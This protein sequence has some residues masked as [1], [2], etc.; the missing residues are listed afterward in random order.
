MPTALHF[1]QCIYSHAVRILSSEL[2]HS[3]Y[4]P[5][6]FSEMYTTPSFVQFWRGHISTIVEEW[7]RGL[8]PDSPPGDQ[9]LVSCRS[10]GG[11]KCKH[12][13]HSLN[14]FDLVS[15]TFW[16]EI[17]MFVVKLTTKLMVNHISYTLFLP[18]EEHS[19]KGPINISTL[20]RCQ[21]LSI[22]NV[23]TWFQLT[24]KVPKNYID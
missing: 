8:V 13:K 6:T 14:Y 22:K 21:T 5:Q 12:L 20:R 3:V 1:L 9:C 18:F 19:N 17:D 24:T 11:S 10:Q 16:I 7:P 23:S 2:S 4:K 15:T